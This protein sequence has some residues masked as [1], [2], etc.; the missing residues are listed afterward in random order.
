MRNKLLFAGIA[1]LAVAWL[2]P[3]PALAEEAFFGHMLMHMLVVA[4]AAPLVALGLAGGRWDLSQRYPAV[5][6][7]IPASVAELVLVW[8]WHAP[9]LHHLARMH[10]WGLVAEQ[11]SFLA[12][13][14]WVWL[15]AFGGGGDRSRGR[16]ASGVV[17]LLL[18]SMHMTLLGALLAL[19]SRPVYPH[20]TGYGGMSA[21]E[22]QHLGG[23]VMILIGASAY[24]VG[25]LWLT[26]DLLRRP[27]ADDPAPSGAT[28]ET[29]PA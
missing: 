19:A 29:G 7:P 5:F 12:A 25:G 22:D 9:A 1:V 17:G 13:G 28:S 8:A 4:G 10:G 15:S 2:G 21:L 14:V 16:S 26:G 23:A 27:K 24:L 6:A 18:T 3:L 20:H 11:G